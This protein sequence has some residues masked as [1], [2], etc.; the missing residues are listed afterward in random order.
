VRTRIKCD[1]LGLDFEIVLK[2]PGEQ[3]VRV[4]VETH[5][6]LAKGA[7]NSVTLTFNSHGTE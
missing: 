3:V 6:P 5:P 2:D 7:D 1:E 4:S